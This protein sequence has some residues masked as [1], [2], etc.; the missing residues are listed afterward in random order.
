MQH[1][2]YMDG[3]LMLEAL[4]CKL[5]FG[6]GLTDWSIHTGRNVVLQQDYGVPQVINDGVS[7]ARAI[8]L[9]DPIENAGAQLIKEV[10]STVCAIACHGQAHV[11]APIRRC[12]RW[13]MYASVCAC[14]ELYS[15]ILNAYAYDSIM[16]PCTHCS[17]IKCKHQVG[18]VLG[19]FRLS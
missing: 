11:P 18:M 4:Y 17:C 19:S 15:C 12:G 1:D 7:I 3:S 10:C 5:F 16:D 8:T 2:Q 14:V 6:W 9:E 13:H